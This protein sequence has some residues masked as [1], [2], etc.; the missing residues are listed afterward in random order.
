[1]ELSRSGSSVRNTSMSS[2]PPA[3]SAGD[4]LRAPSG[5][6]PDAAT[7]SGR[8]VQVAPPDARSPSMRDVVDADVE[9]Q[10]VRQTPYEEPSDSIKRHRVIVL[11]SSATGAA[12]GFGFSQVV[13]DPSPYLMAVCTTGGAVMGGLAGVVVYYRTRFLQN[14]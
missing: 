7:P 14:C 6:E 5:G 2:G 1:M 11:S 4:V 8:G 13:P 12:L 9:M 10:P 3:P